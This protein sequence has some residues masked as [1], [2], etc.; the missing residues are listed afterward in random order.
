M[1]ATLTSRSKASP[2][3]ANRSA[4][5]RR[6]ASSSVTSSVTTSA[7]S[8]ISARVFSAP[9]VSM[10][11]STA[12]APASASAVA[13]ARP[14]PLAAPVTSATRPA[15]SVVPA[16]CPRS[17]HRRAARCSAPWPTLAEPRGSCRADLHWGHDLLPRQ[18]PAGHRGGRPRRPSRAE[19]PHPRGARGQR[20]P[21][22]A[23]L[24]RR[25]ADRRLRGRLLLGCRE[26][27]LGNPRRL[28][29]G[30]GL[31]RRPHAESH[32]RGGV[33][34]THRSYGGGAGGL[35]SGRCVLRAAAQ[36][37]LGGARP[38]PGDAPGQRHRHP[39]PLG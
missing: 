4:T 11:P 15:S 21:H 37:V 39:V 16:I 24:P 13:T 31:R 19:L 1:P 12:V 32:L 18:D 36:G 17:P 38:H 7:P 8:P 6:R 23:A 27:L 9:S 20:Q 5:T 2:C 26:G 30:G 29:D 10:S 14:S 3:R 33:L 35:R 34:G 28:L 22:P 25:H